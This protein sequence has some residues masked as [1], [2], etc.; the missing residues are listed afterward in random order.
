MASNWNICG[1]CDLRNISKQSVI[2]CSDCEEGLCDDCKDHHSLS[3][4]TRNHETVTI[5]EYQKLP[6]NVVQIAQS[7]RKHDQKYQIFCKKH[8]CP[9]CKRCVVEDH[10]KCEDLKDID[11]VISGIKSSNAFEDIEKTLKEVKEHIERIRKDREENLASLQD[12][13]KSIVIE[14]QKAK[15][16]INNHLDQLHQ[17]LLRD[18]DTAEETESMKIRQLLSEVEKN[19]KEITEF[20]AALASIK[21]YASDLQTF[22]AVKDMERD[23]TKNENFVHTITKSGKLNH[24]RMTLNIETIIQNIAIDVK[25]FGEIIVVN[26][27]N[28]LI[29]RRQK[30]QQA[31]QM[32][33]APVSK[34]I[35]NLA[36]T[37]RRTVNTDAADIRGCTILPDGRMMF[38]CYSKHKIIVINK[39]GTTDFEI[40]LDRCFDM[41]YI[42]NNKIAV[43]SG[44]YF[45]SFYIN[46]VDIEQRIVTEV[47]DVQSKNLG[48]VLTGEGTLIYCAGGTGMKTIDLSNKTRGS[49][50]SGPLSIS[51]YSYVTIYD[52]NILYTNQDIN[53]VTCSD[54]QGTTQW[55]FK[56]KRVLKNPQG[57]SVD[58]DGNVYVAGTNSNSV[59]VVSHDGKHH[60]QILSNAEG[61]LK[62]QTV[63]YD[64]SSDLLLVANKM[65]RAFLYDVK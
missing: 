11:D 55:E 30:D 63:H 31:Q 54:F 1:V 21:Q 40:K 46:C 26:E 20:Q 3:K 5:A 13:K 42:G 17:T 61:L 65:G 37:L 33:V 15:T 28:E 56:N 24:H 4:G 57:I 35:D 60:R 23:L 7:C 27:P 16:S 41:V 38:T 43:T 53:T 39:Y 44:R 6:S 52:K 34:S 9:C 45:D 25:S 48:V 62:P 2:W 10:N 32:I 29:I 58:K 50:R 64:Q 59:V 36:L 12:Q 8:D 51:G 14:I 19:E 18:L 22:L 47:L 49:I